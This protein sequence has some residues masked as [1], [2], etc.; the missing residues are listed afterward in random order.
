M[1][2]SDNRTELKHCRQLMESLLTMRDQMSDLEKKVHQMPPDAPG[3]VGA[4]EWLDN[5]QDVLLDT[6]DS[7]REAEADVYDKLMRTLRTERV[8]R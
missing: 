6:M 5:S 4:L 2:E 7:L 3:V 8:T 1:T